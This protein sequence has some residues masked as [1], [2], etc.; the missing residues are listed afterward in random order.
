MDI[1]K[2]WEQIALAYV[3]TMPYYNPFKDKLK[4]NLFRSLDNAY[5]VL[6]E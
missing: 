5:K 1:N 6:S 3:Y 2:A 4:N